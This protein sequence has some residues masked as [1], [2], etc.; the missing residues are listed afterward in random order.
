VALQASNGKYMSLD[1]STLRL[2][3]NSDAINKNTKFKLA[4]KK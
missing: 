4:D 1:E 2:Y 3:A